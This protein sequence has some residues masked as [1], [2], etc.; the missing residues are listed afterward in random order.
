MTVLDKEGL[1][2]L[3]QCLIDAQT[4]L[5]SANDMRGSRYGES[6]VTEDAGAMRRREVIQI[7]RI[8]LKVPDNQPAFPFPV[9]GKL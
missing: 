9:R 7:W 5:E 6:N 4:L 3:L 8:R 1:L 2:E